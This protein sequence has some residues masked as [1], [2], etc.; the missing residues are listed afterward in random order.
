MSALAA[1][2]GIIADMGEPLPGTASAQ[3]QEA[4][5]AMAELI[6]AG[7]ELVDAHDAWLGPNRPD[8][9]VATKRML[10]AIDRARSGA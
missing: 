7:K 3:L 4:R 10:A 5:S 2:D 8:P 6:E 1:I 9:K